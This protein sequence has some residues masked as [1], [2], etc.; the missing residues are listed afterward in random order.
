MV[1]KWIKNTQYWI[2]PPTCA[3]CGGGGVGGRDLCWGCLEELPYNLSHCAV[4]A[5]PLTESAHGLHCGQ[6]ANKR[7][8]FER[9]LTAFHYAPPVDELILGL[10]FGRRLNHARLLGDLLADYLEPRIEPDALPEC[11][12]PV[13]LHRS[14]LRER[15]FNQAVEL[16][17]PVAKQLGI[18]LLHSVCRRTRAT[19]VQTGLTALERRRNIKN[20]FTATGLRNLRHVAI[21]DDVVT[22][23]TTVTELTRVLKRAGVGHVEVWAACRT[24]QP[25]HK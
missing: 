23:G 11:L 4:C 25:T 2:Y 8:P 18:P 15:G 21:V 20:T 22:T 12:I 3:L 24:P 17:R 9:C 14:R 5:L 16:A 1:Y 10:K 13:P 19:P 7:P 6:C